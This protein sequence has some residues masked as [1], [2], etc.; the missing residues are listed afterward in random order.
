MKTF[1][2]RANNEHESTAIACNIYGVALSSIDQA[3]YESFPH[4]T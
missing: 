2:N 3:G 4:S 1:V